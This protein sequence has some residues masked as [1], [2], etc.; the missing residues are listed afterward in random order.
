LINFDKDRIPE[1]TLKAVASITNNE[2]FNLEKIET[3]S[4]G[5]KL[6]AQWIIAIEKYGK[7][8]RFA[9]FLKKTQK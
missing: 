2:E 6:L 1:K 7:V 8:Y 5:A 4:T 9:G 3:L